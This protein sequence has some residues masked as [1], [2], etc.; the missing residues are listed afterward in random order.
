MGPAV[1]GA[2]FVGTPVVGRAL[3]DPAG[4]VGPT[5]VGERRV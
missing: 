4:T 1:V 2:M 3:G 5:V